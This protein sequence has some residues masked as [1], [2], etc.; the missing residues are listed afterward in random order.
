MYFYYGITHST[1]ENPTEEIEL[2]I[3][4]TYGKQQVSDYKDIEKENVNK[5][6]KYEKSSCYKHDSS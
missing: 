5:W 3:D 4:E 6:L 2:T 1:L